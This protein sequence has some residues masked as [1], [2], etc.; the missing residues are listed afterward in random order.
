MIKGVLT[1]PA[2]R[3]HVGRVAIVFLLSLLTGCGDTSILNDD[4]HLDAPSFAA[5]Y[6]TTPV[7]KLKGLKGVRTDNEG[8]DGVLYFE[9]D[10]TPSLKD[11][12]SYKRGGDLI[13]LSDR[14]YGTFPDKNAYPLFHTSEVDCLKMEDGQD[15]S[16]YKTRILMHNRK[17][18]GYFFFRGSYMPDLPIQVGPTSL[19]SADAPEEYYF[20]GITFDRNSNPEKAR[21]DFNKAIE[22]IPDCANAYYRRGVA[23]PRVIK[24]QENYV[25]TLEDYK[26]A[27]ELAPDSYTVHDTLMNH[28]LNVGKLDLARQEAAILIKLEPRNKDTIEGYLRNSIAR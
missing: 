7:D 23:I 5:R 22:L 20:R 21:A 16:S 8:N 24:K 13:N 25:R 9:S 19:I 10:S 17:T 18:K 1:L 27:L 11:A 3:Y 6:F 2:S 28:Y 15:R 12:N 26:K 4:E 14:F